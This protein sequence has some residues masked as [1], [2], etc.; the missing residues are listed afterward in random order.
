MRRLWAWYL[1]SRLSALD[2]RID[3]LRSCIAD[4]ARELEAA[5]V[6]RSGIQSDL[7]VA[8]NLRRPVVGNSSRGSK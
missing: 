1:R 7:W 4:D 8:E 2:D 5:R 3:W 6:K